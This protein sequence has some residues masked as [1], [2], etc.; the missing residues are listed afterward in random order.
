MNIGLVMF[1]ILAVG[2]VGMALYS[3]C[4][5]WPYRRP[6]V[7]SRQ[8]IQNVLIW[9]FWICFLIDKGVPLALDV[10]SGRPTSPVLE[11]HFGWF[12]VATIT[13]L[14]MNVLV[15]IFT[16]RDFTIT[17]QPHECYGQDR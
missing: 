13:F 11:N 16:S 14:V 5:L 7:L 15:T 9:M 10:A 4:K 12:G 1:I 3:T 17:W 8:E 2:G 6:G